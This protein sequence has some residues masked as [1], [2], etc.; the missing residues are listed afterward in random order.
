M[1][2]GFRLDYNKYKSDNGDT[3]VNEDLTMSSLETS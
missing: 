2:M 3:P 1:H